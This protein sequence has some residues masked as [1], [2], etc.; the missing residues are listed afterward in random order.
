[1]RPSSSSS[2][3]KLVSWKDKFVSSKN[4]LGSSRY[5]LSKKLFWISSSTHFNSGELSSSISNE[6]IFENQGSAMPSEIIV[7]KKLEDFSGF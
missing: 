6:W 2:I 5:S 4:S 7:E 3:S 1:M